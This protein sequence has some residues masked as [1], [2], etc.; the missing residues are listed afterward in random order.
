AGRSHL[1]SARVQGACRFYAAGFEGGE[2]V[3]VKEDHGTTVLARA[4]F[5]RELG[6]A[7][8]LAVSVTGD[9]LSLA[10][11]GQEVVSATDNAYRYGM[12]GLR[13]ASHGRMT[14]SRLEIADA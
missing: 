2:A 5:A 1:V 6:R 13:M 7:Y 3:I 4:P 11:D 8:R 10:I 14:V 9:R 12:A